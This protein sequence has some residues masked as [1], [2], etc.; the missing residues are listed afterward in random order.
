M[1]EYYLYVGKNLYNLAIIP[2]Y[3]ALLLVLVA[4]LQG[5]Y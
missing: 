4:N 1:K 3:C 2:I 5:T